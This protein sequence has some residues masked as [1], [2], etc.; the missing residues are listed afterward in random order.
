MIK[1]KVGSQSKPSE[2]PAQ[3]PSAKPKKPKAKSSDSPTS[4]V[5][6]APPPP[7]VDDGSHD[8]LQEV[9]A[10]EREKNEQRQRSVSEKDKPTANVPLGKRKKTDL[11]EDDILALAAPAKKERPSPPGPSTIKVQPQAPPAASVSKSSLPSI[12][13]RKDKSGH[14]QR[15]STESAVPSLK[16]KEKEIHVSPAPPPVS[17]PTPTPVPS[18]PPS[19]PKR[20]SVPSTPINE[21]KCKELL[22]LLMKYPESEIFMRPVDSA[23]DGC[24]TYVYFIP[25]RFQ[26]QQGYT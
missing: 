25:S 20:K 15:P 19:Q 24:P 12:K 10:I 6:Y 8:I 4:L 26:T 18:V 5:L 2:R 13:F 21:K 17:V 22:K 1:L 16:G 11:V 9:L 3:P 23:L 7:Y 14:A